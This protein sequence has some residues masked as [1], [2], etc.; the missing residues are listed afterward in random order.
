M[1]ALPN[2]TPERVLELKKQAHELKAATGKKQSAVLAE[3]AKRE[4][5]P[6]WEVLIARAGGR[7]EVDKLKYSATPTEGQ[8]KRAARSR[9]YGVFKA[10]GGAS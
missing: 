4:G 6:S 8:L 7:E 2:I 1:S 3:I 5:F 9:R 10:E